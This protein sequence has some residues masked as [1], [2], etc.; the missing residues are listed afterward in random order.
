MAIKFKC[1][2][3]GKKQKFDDALGGQN[4][5]C[6]E[7][8][9]VLQLPWSKAQMNQ[10]AVA[11]QQQAAQ[12]AA[13]LAAQFETRKAALVIS[14]GPVHTPHAILQIVFAAGIQ[15][16]GGKGL[17]TADSSALTD[18]KYNE[19]I[20]QVYVS[21]INTF[22]DKAARV[23]ADAI[24]HAK[25]DIE[26]IELA[27]AGLVSVGNALRIQVFCTGTAVRYT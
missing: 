22:R 25:F 26:Q 7:C 12:H 16:F 24:I 2:S 13:N 3:C 5:Q 20:E 27:E 17:F 8:Q 14:T 6:T 9:Q 21:A 19:M 1:P 10:Q 23:G 15:K 18:A 11:E 4:Q